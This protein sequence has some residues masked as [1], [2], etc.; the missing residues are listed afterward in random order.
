MTKA[1]KQDLLVSTAES[2]KGAVEG[3][4][5]HKTIVNIYNNI[6]PLPGGYKLKYSDAWCAAFVSVIFRVVGIDFPFECSCE[7][8]R[9]KAEKMGIWVERDDYTPNIGDVVLYDWQDSGAGDNTGYPDHAGLVV[10]VVGDMIVT[11]EGNVSNQVSNR[12]LDMN[13]KYI[14]GYITPQINDDLDMTSD[15]LTWAKS[16][17]IDYGEHWNDTIRITYAEMFQILYKLMR[18]NA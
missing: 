8:M 10:N 11:V 7:R 18:G 3:S 14:R 17:G 1:E 2:Y 13:G 4:H 9:K 16:H 12:F 15:W 6:S 5:Q